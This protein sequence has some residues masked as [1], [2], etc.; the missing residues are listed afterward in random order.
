MAAA[1]LPATVAAQSIDL[2]QRVSPDAEMLLEADTIV[3]DNDRNTITAVGGVQ[4]DYDGNRLVA[5]RI[6]YDRATSRLIASGNVEIVDPDGT[7]IFSDQID[8][9][10]DFRDAFVRTLR[11]ETADKTYFAAE[12]ADRRD[13]TLTTFNYGVYT[14]CE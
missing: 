8:V 14:A 2:E 11:V 5:Q 6:T 1:L 12:S 4:I 7:R 9:T 3:Y 10:D 13:G